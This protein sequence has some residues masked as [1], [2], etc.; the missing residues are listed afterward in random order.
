M[1]VSGPG[2]IIEAL[3]NTVSKNGNLLLNI[4]PTAEGEIPKAQQETLL[5]VGEW[6]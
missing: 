3:A 2:L 6:R 5:A 4:S 1:R